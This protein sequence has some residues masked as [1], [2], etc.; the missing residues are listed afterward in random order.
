MIDELSITSGFWIGLNHQYN[1]WRWDTNVIT[2]RR[3]FPGINATNFFAPGR[4][5]SSRDEC[6]VIWTSN[7]LSY[8]V[9][10]WSR[11]GVLCEKQY[12]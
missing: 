8:D 9:S 11:Y 1:E 2:H 3:S 7:L 12:S 6:V 10:C 4:P 5:N